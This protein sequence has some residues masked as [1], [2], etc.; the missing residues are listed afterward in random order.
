MKDLIIIN[1]GTLVSGDVKQPILNHTA[2]AIRN[3]VI[4]QLGGDELLEKYPQAKV[5]DAKGITVAPGLIDSHCHPCAGDYTFRQQTANFLESE[6]HGGVT[7][8]I[9]AGEPHFPGRPTDV[10]GVKAQS[11]FLSKSFRNKSPLGAKVHAGAVILEQGLEEKDFIEMKEAGVWLVGEVGLG[12]VKSADDAAPLVEIAKKHGFKVAMHVGG[13]SLPGSSPVS[14]DDVIK[15]NPTVASHC[16]GGPTSVSTQEITRI[17][18][19]SDCA[20][21]IVQC[22]NYKTA[23]HILEE[24]RTRSAEDRVILG[25]DAPS[26]SGMI[27]LGILR[28]ISYISSVGGVKPEIAVAMATGNTARYFGLNTGILEPGREADLVFLDAPIG[29]VAST[30]LEALEAGD[31]P[32]VTYVIIDGRVAVTKSRNTPPGEREPEFIN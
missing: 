25:N 21:E 17:I 4:E 24:I 12:T 11:I 9:S 28:N 3:G 31:L 1:I 6:I 29:S 16:N 15:V 10:A 26:G 22:G 23:L 13:T 5:I 18:D 27:P 7:T 19:E 30:A 2:I 32:A 20:I 14:A 8:L